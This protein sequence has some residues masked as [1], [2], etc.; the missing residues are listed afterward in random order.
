[1][2]L[3]TI[4]LT[5]KELVA[6]DTMAFHFKKPEGFRYI[7][8]QYGDFTLINPPETDKE[9]DK[10][11]FSFAS[12][13]HEPDLKITTR[14]RDTAF[15]RTLRNLPEGSEVQL[16]GPFGSL[17]LPKNTAKTAVFLTGGIGATLVR[18]IVSQAIHDHTTHKMI[19]LYSNHTKDDSV[20][21]EE[22]MSLAKTH[23]N[24]LFI[25]I[26]TDA[27]SEWTGEHDVIDRVMLEKYIP[28]IAG[29]IYYLSGPSAMVGT[30]RKLLLDAHVDRTNI[31]ADQFIGY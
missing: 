4:T 13:P 8:G 2:P 14:L 5:K 3:Y 6:N 21:F 28:D 9:G 15:K 24:F 7:A 26:M 27:T 31:R 20:F 29:S 22:F 12:A 30:M 19:F 18:S 11:T 17:A 23:D 16:E 25:P 10:R 1:M